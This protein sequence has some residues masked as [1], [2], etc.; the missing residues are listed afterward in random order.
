MWSYTLCVWLHILAAAA[1]VG[2]MVFFAAVVVPVL[3]RA[4]DPRATAELVRAVGRRYRVLGWIALGV[5][6]VTGVGNLYF[7]GIGWSDLMSPAWRASPF[8]R[9]L[10]WKLGLVDL[11]LL[12]TAGHELLTGKRALEAMARDPGSPAALR[13]RRA[14]SWLGRATML[15]SLLVLYLAVALVR[16]SP[17][18]D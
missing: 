7:R 1:W 16:G 2:S 14:A 13:A 3:R 5:L 15:L 6:L 11:V 10:M 9:A 12:A 8:G 18:F 17:L 4:P